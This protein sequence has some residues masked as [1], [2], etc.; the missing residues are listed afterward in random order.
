MSS[1]DGEAP[2]AL[3]LV[4]GGIAMKASWDVIDD[5]RAGRLVRVRLVGGEILVRSGLPFRKASAN[6]S[7]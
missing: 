2:H 3:A 5:I 6:P 1:L 4:G 7:E